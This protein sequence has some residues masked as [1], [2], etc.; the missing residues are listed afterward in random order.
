MGTWLLDFLHSSHIIIFESSL[1]DVQAP[2]Q[3]LIVVVHINIAL[4]FQAASGLQF[5][6]MNLCT[7]QT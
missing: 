4:S 1:Q 3:S 5:L 2:G 7:D 6:L